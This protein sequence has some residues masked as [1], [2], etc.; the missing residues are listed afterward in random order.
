MLRLD[1]TSKKRWM[2]FDFKFKKF[3]IKKQFLLDIFLSRVKEP[4]QKKLKV[5]FVVFLV[6]L[7]VSKKIYILTIEV[8]KK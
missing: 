3:S 5:F 2:G 8:K 1:A 7:R 6:F 4:K